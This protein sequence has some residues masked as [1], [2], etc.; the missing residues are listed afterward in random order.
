MRQFS[1]PR[2]TN[3]SPYQLQRARPGRSGIRG[4]LLGVIGQGLESVDDAQEVEPDWLVHR[5]EPL[6]AISCRLSALRG[7]VSVPSDGK[8]NM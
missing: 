6:V 2:L 8:R 5:S 3:V 1:N 4:L 7:A